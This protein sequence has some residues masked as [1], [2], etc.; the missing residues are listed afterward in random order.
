MESLAG[1]AHLG[2]TACRVH[3]GAQVLKAVATR[4]QKLLRRAVRAQKHAFQRAILEPC[5][6]ALVCAK[7]VEDA[8]SSLAPMAPFLAG[9][10]MG[11]LVPGALTACPESPSIYLEH[12]ECAAKPLA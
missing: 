1:L 6:E 10:S 12:L 2:A 5:C 3:A 11:T 4:E 7:N 8:A 9:S